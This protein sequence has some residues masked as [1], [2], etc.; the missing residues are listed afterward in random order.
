MEKSIASD[1]RKAFSMRESVGR[2]LD[3]AVE[4]MFGGHNVHDILSPIAKR[5]EFSIVFYLLALGDEGA[6]R[7]LVETRVSRAA[8]DFLKKTVERYGILRGTV[9]DIVLRAHG[10]ANP[11]DSMRPR[12]SWN[13]ERNTP[14]ISVDVLSA[15]RVVFSTTDDADDILR[16]ARALLE[17]V[18]EALGLSE[19]QQK[20]DGLGPFADEAID[21]IK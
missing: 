9:Q 8:K 21:D 15:G 17:T 3:L 5:P 6:S 4:S 1:A 20:T 13:L 18:E 11:W 7:I 12:Y 10:K 16:L 19:G 14:Q 2:T